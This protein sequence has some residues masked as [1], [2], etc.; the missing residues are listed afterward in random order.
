M[1]ELIKNQEA[2]NKVFETNDTEDYL[3]VKRSLWRKAL[4]AIGRKLSDRMYRRFYGIEFIDE[5]DEIID[6]YSE[7]LINN[8]VWKIFPWHFL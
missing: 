5:A 3:I 2:Y 7:I 8:E 1:F 4:R 6:E